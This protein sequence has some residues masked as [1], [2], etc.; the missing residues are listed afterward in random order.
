MITGRDWV[1]AVGI[2]APAIVADTSGKAI[3][4]IRDQ[5]VAYLG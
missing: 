3:F 4:Q 5:W 2:L 1:T